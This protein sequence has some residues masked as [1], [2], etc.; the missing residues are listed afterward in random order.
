M[1]SSQQHLTP[2]FYWVDVDAQDYVSRVYPILE[3]Y[4]GAD[5]GDAIKVRRTTEGDGRVFALFEVLPGAD[6]VLGAEML[7]WTGPWHAATPQTTVQDVVQAP[8]VE[9]W[10]ETFPMPGELVESTAAKLAG[11]TAMIAGG[12]LALVLLV[13]GRR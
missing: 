1:P 6:V 7:T 2:G 12:A 11:A 8:T 5:G 10:T 13:R 3:L 9:H 4:I